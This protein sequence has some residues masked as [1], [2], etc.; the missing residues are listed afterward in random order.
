MPHDGPF[1]RQ[2]ATG[3]LLGYLDRQSADT[4]PQIIIGRPRVRWIWCAWSPVNESVAAPVLRVLVL[5]AHRSLS[6]GVRSK[7]AAVAPRP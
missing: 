5:R 6:Y 1:L 7:A 4:A 2:R 3:Q